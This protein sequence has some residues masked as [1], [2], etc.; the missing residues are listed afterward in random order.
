MERRRDRPAYILCDRSPHMTCTETTRPRLVHTSP[1][2][3]VTRTRLV[4]EGDR[5]GVT[6]DHQPY[7][8]STTAALNGWRSTRWLTIDVLLE[9]L[10]LWLAR[11]PILFL[12]P[13]CAS[14]TGVEFWLSMLMLS[15]LF[16]VTARCR[17]CLTA[18]LSRY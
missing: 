2:L 16:R 9:Q 15:A 5:K 3:A 1:H 8:Q 11:F 12:G 10:H 14:I 17:V 13:P 6:S 18:S 4:S 7:V